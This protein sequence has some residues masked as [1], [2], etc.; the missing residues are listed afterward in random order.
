[1]SNI[2]FD[3]ID[4]TF[5]VSGVD[6]S[7][8]GFRD[9]F[10]YIKTNFQ[11][12]KSEIEYLQDNTSKINDDNN[13]NGVLV[14]DANFLMCSEKFHNNGIVSTSTPISFNSGSYQKV[15]VSNDVTLT[16]MDWSDDGRLARIW[17]EIYNNPSQG[18]PHVITFSAGNGKTLF[19]DNSG[20]LTLQGT[21]SVSSTIHPVMIEF[22]THDAG[23]NVFARFV[24]SYTAV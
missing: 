23:E 21:L 17:L 6:N 14:A 4:E 20:V 11:Y 16:L 12:A 3:A 18:T 9:N 8:Q 5:P 10:N 1:M 13:F 22:F 19:V 15:T 2:N 7:S 24:G